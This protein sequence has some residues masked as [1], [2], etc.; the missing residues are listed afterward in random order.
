MVN[1]VVR[2][3]R[4]GIFIFGFHTAS[5]LSY[6]GT[7]MPGFKKNIYIGRRLLSNNKERRR[8]LLNGACFDCFVSLLNVHDVIGDQISF[9]HIRDN[10]LDR[11]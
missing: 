4:A 8:L 10:T 3:C 9:G 11:R 1:P 7:I 6:I 2:E 5:V